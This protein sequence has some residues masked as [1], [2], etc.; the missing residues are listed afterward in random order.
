MKLPMSCLISRGNIKTF[1]GLA[2]VF[3]SGIDRYYYSWPA[4]DTVT[5]RSLMFGLQ[6]L[7]TSTICKYVPFPM[8]I[9]LFYDFYFSGPENTQ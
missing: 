1:P 7:L 6:M 2:R 4:I 5:S 9:D 8:S 3:V